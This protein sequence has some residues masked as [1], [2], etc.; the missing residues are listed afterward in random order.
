MEN[1]SK[2]D[3][4]DDFVME[5]SIIVAWKVAKGDKR[6]FIGLYFAD[7]EDSKESM[8]EE[9]QSEE[10]PIKHNVLVPSF[11]LE[12]INKDEKI[13]LTLSNLKNEIWSWED[14][15]KMEEAAKELF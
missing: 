3:E 1:K 15:S 14:D 8:L 9:N 5:G 4:L 2:F 10:N 13:E 7:A 12:N 6:E 11:L